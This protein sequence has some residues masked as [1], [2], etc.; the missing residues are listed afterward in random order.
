[1]RLSLPV[2]TVSKEKLT[3]NTNEGKKGGIPGHFSFSSHGNGKKA[4]SKENVFHHFLFVV[5]IVV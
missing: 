1:V 3:E 5:K 2:Q 4:E